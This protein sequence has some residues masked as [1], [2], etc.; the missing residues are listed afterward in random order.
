ME[1]PVSSRFFALSFRRLKEGFKR[2][3]KFVLFL[4][5]FYWLVCFLVLPRRRYLVHMM[6]VALA[7]SA[8]G[9]IYFNEWLKGI[10]KVRGRVIAAAAAVILVVAE[11]SIGMASSEN[12]GWRKRRPDFI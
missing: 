11:L 8:Q 3:E 5:G 2:E 1:L 12:K 6:P 4:A 10:F 7:L 9:A